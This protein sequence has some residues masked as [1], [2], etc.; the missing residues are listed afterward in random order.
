VAVVKLLTTHQRWFEAEVPDRGRA[1]GVLESWL[2][3]SDVQGFLQVNRYQDVLWYNQEAFDELLWWMLAIAAVT[4]TADPHR[5]A[6]QV[7][8]EIE[9][10]GGVIEQLLRAG[11][12]SE[13]QVEQLLAVLEA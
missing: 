2:Q 6:A 5:P 8:G 13:Y 7:T 10:C 3:D 9:G 4:L 12:G 1:Y 11:E